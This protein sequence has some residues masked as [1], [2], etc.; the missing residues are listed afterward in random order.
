M[1]RSGFDHEILLLQGGGALGAYQAGVYEG[2][3]EAGIAPTW[4]VGIS[5]GAINAALIAGNPPER[6]IERLREFWRRMSVDPAAPLPEWLDLLGPAANYMAAM[7]AMAFGIPG[8]FTPR[9]PPPWFAADGAE[10]ALSMYDTTPLG[11]TLD[12]LVDF[13]LINSGPVRLSLGAVNVCKGSSVYF[14]TDTGTDSTVIT[15]DH[16]RASGALPPGFPPVT[17]E[18]EHYWD[19]GVVTNTPITY[20]ADQR[21]MT[22]ARI[23][24]VDNFMAQ[25]ELPQNLGEV[26]ER[27]KD[28]QYASRS[29]FNIDRLQELGEIEAA[30]RRLLDKLPP[31]LKSDPDAQKLAEICDERSWMIIRLINQTPLAVGRR[32]GL[33]VFPQDDRGGVGGRPRRRAP[34]GFRLGRRPAQGNRPWRSGLPADR[35]PAPSCPRARR[36]ATADCCNAAS[37]KQKIKADRDSR[38]KF[39][40]TIPFRGRELV[41]MGRLDCRRLL[42]PVLLLAPAIAHAQAAPGAPTDVQQRE[43]IERQLQALARSR[44]ELSTM[45]QNLQQQVTDFDARIAALEAKLG[46]APATD[47]VAQADDALA[48][49]DQAAARLP[50]SSGGGEGQAQAEAGQSASAKEPGSLQPGKGI[51]LVEGQGRGVGVRRKRLRALPQSGRAEQ[52]LYGLVWAEI[53]DRQAAGL[54]AEPASDQLPGMVVR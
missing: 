40:P 33:R 36:F 23:V 22:T 16:V 24:Q 50:P 19:G 25:G 4:V 48:P 26:S 3:A 18:G 11:R 52:Q 39:H 43:D 46:V 8:F 49:A 7:S 47:A 14:D 15:A 45:Q 17:I 42:L 53:P 30:M 13:D 34:V 9:I 28:I 10:A 12:E 54:S 31:D 32:K 21:P 35:R 1:V 20:V 44:Q 38:D 5:I 51:V 6:R 27:R 37:R 29:R 2:L 41:G